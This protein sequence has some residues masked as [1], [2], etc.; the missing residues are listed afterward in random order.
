VPCPGAAGSVCPWSPGKRK[1]SGE[2]DLLAL[3]PLQPL[4]TMTASAISHRQCLSGVGSFEGGFMR[5]RGAANLWR[6]VISGSDRDWGRTFKP[7][8]FWRSLKRESCL[9]CLAQRGRI[10]LL[11]FCYGA[12][13]FIFQ[14]TVPNTG[15]AHELRC[16]P[17]LIIHKAELVAPLFFQLLSGTA[18]GPSAHQ[19]GRGLAAR[20][21]RSKGMS[22]INHYW[23][24]P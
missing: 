9:A 17:P 6:G 13:Q 15:S 18:R 11:W 4:L 1:S 5:M 16:S 22:A 10:H 20:P 12:K 21:I 14:Q 2:M 8:P 19:L 23:I 7:G 24:H 3:M